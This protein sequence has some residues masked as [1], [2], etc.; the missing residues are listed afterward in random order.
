MYLARVS[1]KQ[2]HQPITHV[3]VNTE[4]VANDWLLLAEVRPGV[5][6][7]MSAYQLAIALLRPR[8]AG[9]QITLLAPT[10]T[11][12]RHICV[13]RTDESWAVWPT[14]YTAPPVLAPACQLLMR[15]PDPRDDALPDSRP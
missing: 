7:Y 13:T 3:F 10:H 8:W 12:D 1:P 5:W 4:I 11:E 9:V 2:L 6:D 14:P 15:G